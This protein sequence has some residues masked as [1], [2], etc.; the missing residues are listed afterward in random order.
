[1]VTP[2]EVPDALVEKAGAVIKETVCA[3]WPAYISDILSLHLAREVL[4]AVLPEAQAQAWDDSHEHC[5]GVGCKNPYQTTTEVR[6]NCG[7]GGFHDDGNPHCDQ[8]TVTTEE[9]RT[10][11]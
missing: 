3:N 11:P 6:C 4:A 8:N 5:D 10:C 2:Y 7:F 1:M 9:P